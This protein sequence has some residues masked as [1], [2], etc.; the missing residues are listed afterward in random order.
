[1][2]LALHFVLIAIAMKHVACF[3]LY[4]GFFGM[5]QDSRDSWGFFF[6]EIL[7]NSLEFLRIFE[8]SSGFFR[9]LWDSRDF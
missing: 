2:S 6:L 9:I 4:P 8:D 1:M 3:N 7:H 5:L